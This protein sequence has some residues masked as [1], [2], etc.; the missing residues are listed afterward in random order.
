MNDTNTIEAGLLALSA[1]DDDH[2]QVVNGV[3]FNGRDTVFGNSLADQL[4]AGRTLTAKQ[5]QAAYKILRT[6]RRQLSNYG[7]DYDAILA[8]TTV[9]HTPVPETKVAEVIV[10]RAED[11]TPKGEVVIEQT[12]KGLIG[13]ISFD[14][15]P[16]LV[17]EVKGLVGRRWDKATKTWTVP[18][19]PASTAAVMSFAD[20]HGFDL[21]HD[22]LLAE[23]RDLR[24]RSR[25]IDADVEVEGF[26][27]STLIPFPF[28]RAGIDYAVAAKRTFIA[29]EMG[30]GKTVQALG[31]IAATKAFPAIIVCPAAVKLSWRDHI[32]AWLPGRSVQV[33]RGTKPQAITADVVITN[34]DIIATT[35]GRGKG[36]VVSLRA[37][38]A[39]AGFKAVV[40]D[41][42]H[43]CKSGKA[44]R[45]KAAR[46]LADGAEVVLNLTGTPVVNRPAELVEQ[47]R[48][49]GRLDE[50]GGWRHFVTRYC[51]AYQDQFGWNVKGAANLDELND[52][53]RASCYVRRTKADVLEE[54]PELTR[55]KLPVD[56]ASADRR[57]YDDA[58]DDVVAFLSERA[59]AIAE[60]LGE[61]PMSAAVVARIK[62]EAAEHLVRITTL[63]R[64]AA[65]AK[66]EAAAEWISDFLDSTLTNGTGEKL[67]VFAHHVEVIEALAARFDAPMLKGGM[68]DEQK[69]AIVGRF[70]T[71]PHTRVVICG[72][73]AVREGITLTAATNMLFVE[74]GWT[75]GEH[76][77]AEARAYARMN[78]LHG[79]MAWYLQMEHS[80]DADVWSLIESKREVV[81]AVVD[82]DELSDAS[83]M[84]DLLV[85]LAGRGK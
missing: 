12:A 31:T 50:F 69:H 81:N 40:F 23:V 21:V 55:A 7:I 1:R 54:L 34:Y 72:L 36:K 41:E 17:H 42:S 70:Q 10:S 48:L 28:Q 20:L 80:I 5:A 56:V 53:L 9:V 79:L 27:S 73:K 29:D 44:Q 66:I 62:A 4:R 67:I 60:E 39:G 82:G 85:R 76:D 25:A 30:L 47:L 74:Q 26:G 75:P 19:T 58:E 8:P 18:L 63:K 49:L 52:L 32:E 45:T 35:E 24:D 64:L 77:Q 16:R 57:A 61:D 83:I 2:A 71:D 33:L 43:Y 3:G 11:A 14:Y 68:T 15:D 59:A 22:E 84:G 46:V 13:R 38:L 37:D 78:D 6:Y 51:N 65:S